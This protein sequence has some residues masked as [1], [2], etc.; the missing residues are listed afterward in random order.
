MCSATCRQTDAT[1]TAASCRVA[2]ALRLKH[3]LFIISTRPALRSSHYKDARGEAQKHTSVCVS[4]CILSQLILQF[5]CV[6]TMC[7]HHKEH[8][9]WFARIWSLSTTESDLPIQQQTRYSFYYDISSCHQRITTYTHTQTNKMHLCNWQMIS[10]RSN[11]TAYRQ[12]VWI[13]GFFWCVLGWDSNLVQLFQHWLFVISQSCAIQ[14]QPAP[15]DTHRESE[16]M[17]VCNT[18]ITAKITIINCIWSRI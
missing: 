3:I 1:C 2:F 13:V 16:R 6:K 14:F 8:T 11:W 12:C 4:V 15:I 9:E 10:I 5:C 7:K 18:I 17:R